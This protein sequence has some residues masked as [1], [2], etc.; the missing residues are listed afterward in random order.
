MSGL[1]SSAFDCWASKRAFSATS[2]AAAA[3][4][5]AASFSCS[6]ILICCLISAYFLSSAIYL[7][8]KRSSID[9]LIFLKISSLSVFSLT[10]I[11]KNV[12]SPF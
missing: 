3:A 12:F 6:S 5:S 7:N 11:S 4:A 8:F 1:D 9:L 2:A 10:I